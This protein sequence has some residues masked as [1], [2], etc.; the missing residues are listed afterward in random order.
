MEH[1]NI[2]SQRG[3]PSYLNL[4]PLSAWRTPSEAKQ[5]THGHVVVGRSFLRTSF[6][7]YKTQV[8][9]QVLWEL[10]PLPLP[11]PYVTAGFPPEIQICPCICCLA[12]FGINKHTHK[13]LTS[14]TVLGINA[15]E[16]TFDPGHV[17]TRGRQTCF[18]NKM[19]QFSSQ[20]YISES[21]L[22]YCRWV[23]RVLYQNLQ[24]FVF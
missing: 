7:I 5:S 15:C 20:N 8:Q 19:T 22:F 6:I 1:F 3:L 11:L 2:I 4:K 14:H 17:S 9:V 23:C 24:V 21:Q 12:T 16:N 13:L 18:E 10:V